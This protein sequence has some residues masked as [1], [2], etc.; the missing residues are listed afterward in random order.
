MTELWPFVPQREFTESLEWLTDIIPCR[1]AEQ[2]LGVR[3]LPRLGLSYDLLLDHQQAALARTL[4]RTRSLGEFVVPLWS[5]LTR[6]GS[7]P[8]GTTV[9]A[10]DTTWAQYA[11]GRSVVLFDEFDRLEVLEV[12]ELAAGSL[13]LSTGTTLSMANA[14]VMPCCVMRTSQE[15]EFVR[16]SAEDL[17]RVRASF[18]ATDVMDVPGASGPVTYRSYPVLTVQPSIGGSLGERVLHE[19]EEVDNG[20]GPVSVFK[21]LNYVTSKAYM[22]WDCLTVQ[23]LW[24]LRKWLYAARGR[25]RGFWRPTWGIDLQLLSPV[26]AADTTMTV[27]AI[28]F[29]GRMVDRDI[30]VRLLS[31]TT[32]YRRVTSAE[33][34]LAGTE[35]LHLETPLGQAVAPS[36]VDRIS[37]MNF[38]RLDA[39]RVEIRH[40][41][42]RGS[43]VQVPITEVPQP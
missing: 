42:A 30:M 40:R 7:V 12:E 18:Y 20:V 26:S 23:Q 9:L 6:L 11:V 32:I 34:G 21:Q 43:S 29:S 22:A 8:Q 38:A 14:F 4:A 39:D 15:F 25:Q 37:F 33:P 1:A 35:L 10:L 31:G 17:L 27:A 16:A 2:R 3:P 5:E 28:G 19:A 36:A 24:E 41:V 13:T